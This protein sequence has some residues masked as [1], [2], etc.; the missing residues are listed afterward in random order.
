MQVAAGTP[1]AVASGH[2]ARRQGRA[3]Y[4]AGIRFLLFGRTVPA[5]LFGV[6]GWIQL[7][8]LI[9]AIQ[10]LP[11][12][13]TAGRVAGTIVS[14]AL[15]T[16]FCS[17]PVLLYLTR[18]R[19][20]AR[21]GRLVARTAAFAGT[22]MQLLVGA[23]I[24]AGPLIFSPPQLMSDASSVLAVVAFTGAVWALGTLRR[25]LSV[26]PEARRLVTGGPY[27]LVRHPLYLFEILAG[28]AVLL[29]APGWIAMGSYVAFVALQVTRSR[30]EERLLDSTFPGYDD[31]ARRTRRLI[32]FV[33]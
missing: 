6:M 22:T 17:I 18:P 19:P 12:S 3:A 1:Q 16:A 10:T 8:K 24:G 26:I 25:S 13:P 5:T 2:V 20:R 15:Y 32:P 30:L 7:N 23:F 31:Y 29:G 27:R 9:L 33:W 21:D 4:W 11:A 14:P 28:L